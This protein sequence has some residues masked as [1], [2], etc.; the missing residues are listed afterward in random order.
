MSPILNCLIVAGADHSSVAAVSPGVPALVVPPNIAEDVDE[1]PEILP[2]K[3]LPVDKSA[4]SVLQ[5][6]N[7]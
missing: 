1:L 5:V 4:T 3:P 2:A 6:I 7:N